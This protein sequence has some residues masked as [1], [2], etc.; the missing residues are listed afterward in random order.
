MSSWV[1]NPAGAN[2]VN[3]QG[4]Y[5][6]GYCA[7]FILHHRHEIVPFS[8]RLNRQC[9]CGAGGCPVHWKQKHVQ[10]QVAICLPD[11][12]AARSCGPNFWTINAIGVT[13]RLCMYM[14]LGYDRPDAAQADCRA[15]AAHVCYLSGCVGP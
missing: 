6:Q 8:K 14:V 13:S 4:Q 1:G 10:A 12:L 2:F 9:Q 11:L 5:G 7:G 15:V 3:G